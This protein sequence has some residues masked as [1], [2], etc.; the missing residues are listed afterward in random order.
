MANS[1]KQKEE[2]Q[3]FSFNF[4]FDI[5]KSLF[6]TLIFDQ[7]KSWVHDRIL[8]IQESIYL[9][10]RKI[11]ESFLAI[12]LMLVG[13]IMVLISLPFL[14]SYYLNLPASLFFVFL[15]LII[16]ILSLIAFRIINKTKYSELEGD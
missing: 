15:G 6:S 9:V 12:T 7:A 14:L 8:D 4:I 1:K 11:I 13:I 5:F 2:A 3:G 10:F 16:V